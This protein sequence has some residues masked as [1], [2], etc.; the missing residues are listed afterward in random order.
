MFAAA[1]CAAEAG[2][3]V[4]GF[5]AEQGRNA[6]VAAKIPTNK[7]FCS[8]LI[9]D[10]SIWTLETHSWVLVPAPGFR[11]WFGHEVWLFH[12]IQVTAPTRNLFVS[13]H[14]DSS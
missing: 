13:N 2:E 8:V 9:Q 4:G 11:D 14:L 6:C 3:A 10:Y 5:C 7:I 12:H 1:V